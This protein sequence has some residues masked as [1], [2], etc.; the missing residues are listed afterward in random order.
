ML[1]LWSGVKGK[2]SMKTILKLS[3]FETPHNPVQEEYEDCTCLSNGEIY[4][5]EGFEFTGEFRVPK[6][7]EWVLS[8]GRSSCGPEAYLNTGYLIKMPRLIVKPL[9]LK[10]YCFQETGEFRLPVTGEYFLIETGE[11]LLC[12]HENM[13]VSKYKI[14]RKK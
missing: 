7:G 5:P 9:A 11:I 10:E 1:K 4:S 3:D 2:P 14:L 12:D 8:A 13:V 6:E